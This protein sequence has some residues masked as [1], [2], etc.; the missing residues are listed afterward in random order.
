VRRLSQGLSVS[1][2][3]CDGDPEVLRDVAMATNFVF[4][5]S[6][7]ATSYTDF[8]CTIATQALVG[9]EWS[10]D[11]MQIADTLHAPKGR[12][13]G[14]HFWLS[15]IWGAHWRHLANTTEPSMCCGDAA[16]CHIT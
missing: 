11:R 6:I 13:H 8:V 5:D 2:L 4:W 10:A 1:L 3:L 9:F 15:I 16:L 14:N 12:C 7:I